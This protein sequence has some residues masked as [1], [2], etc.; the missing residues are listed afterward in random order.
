MNIII[1]NV[2]YKT[3]IIISKNALKVITSGALQYQ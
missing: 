2:P 1:I 3:K